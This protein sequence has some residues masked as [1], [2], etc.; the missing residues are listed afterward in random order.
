MSLDAPLIILTTD[1]LSALQDNRVQEGKTFEYKRSLPG[2]SYEDKK[3]FLSDVSSFANASGGHILYGIVEEEGIPAAISGLRDINSDTE[4]LRLENLLRDCIQPRIPGVTIKAISLPE[5]KVVIV[6]RVPKSWAQPHAVVFQGHW[7]FYSRTSAGKY[8]LDVPELRAA[9]LLSET[10]SEAIRFFRIER[11]SVISAEETPV[12]LRGSAKLVLHVVPLSILDRTT[13]VDVASMGSHRST[14]APLGRPGFDHRFNLDGFLT[15][16]RS[17][18]DCAG[19]YVQLFRN[20][21]IEA[22]EASILNSIDEERFPRIPSTFLEQ[23]LL[24][25]LPRFIRAQQQLRV[26][27]PLFVMLSLIGLDGHR[28]AVQNPPILD[29]HRYVIDR[30]DLI[31]PEVLID[32]YD[33]DWERVMQP[34]FDALWNAAGW[35]RCGDYTEDGKWKYAHSIQR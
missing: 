27:I 12:P 11:L 16:T 19:S 33:S 24:D 13:W 14:L 9:F 5:S 8:P 17:S 31:L 28:L 2:N 35:P 30:K 1:D 20:G 15:Y 22:V 26:S 23:A 4:I 32:D 25:A 29:P 18:A 3:E 10:A 21:S 6:V 7:R 34:I